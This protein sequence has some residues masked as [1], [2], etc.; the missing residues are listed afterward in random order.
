M[1]V[2]NESVRPLVWLGIFGV[3]L[4]VSTA[5]GAAQGDHAAAVVNGPI[6]FVAGPGSDLFT[7]RPDGLLLRR[8][9]KGPGVDGDPAWSPNGRTTAFDRTSPNGRV[10]SVYLVST[11][12]G[13]P[14]LLVRGARS[15]GWS[16]T[17]RWLAVFRSNAGCPNVGC[18]NAA[19]VWIVPLAGGRPRL[20]VA[21]AW[22]AAWSPSGR[23]LAA[24]RADGIWIVTLATGTMRRLTTISAKTSLDWSPDGSRLLLVLNDSIVTVSTSDGSSTTLLPPP[25]PVLEPPRCTQPSISGPTWSPN[26]RLIAYQREDSCAPGSGQPQGT[27]SIGVIGSDGSD[28]AG[29][30][31]QNTSYDVGAWFYAWSPDSAQLAFLDDEQDSTGHIYLSVASPFTSTIHHLNKDADLGTP[32]WRAAAPTH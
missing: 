5:A 19:N 32:A 10:T 30:G 3:V 8:L 16:P 31:T 28:H 2:L 25:T 23:Q 7:V 6:V 20:A 11:V 1:S 24:M 21:G 18:P 29:I 15:P 17:G 22:S 4:V 14:R 12:G 9:T 27:L 13:E 26:G